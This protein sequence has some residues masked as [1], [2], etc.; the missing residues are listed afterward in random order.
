ML[1][2]LNVL[3][4]IFN[5]LTN[6][7]KQTK[8]NV[9]C[10]KPVILNHGEEFFYHERALIPSISAQSSPKPT[11][12]EKH[13]VV[14]CS[15][16]CNPKQQ[17]DIALTYLL[18]LWWSRSWY[19]SDTKHH[20]FIDTFKIV[21]FFWRSCPFFL[22]CLHQQGLTDLLFWQLYS[23]LAVYFLIQVPWNWISLQ[24]K[25]MYHIIWT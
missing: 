10:S 6:Q 23:T 25:V 20:Q 14:I 1:L 17:M 9:Y 24:S 15:V 2:L 19:S 21:L 16:Q 22:H 18:I 5:L 12:N 13:I 11:T 7:Q 3:H 8:F 4:Y